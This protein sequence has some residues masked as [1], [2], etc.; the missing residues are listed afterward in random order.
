MTSAS[1]SESTA[2]PSLEPRQLRRWL[3]WPLAVVS[4][5][6]WLV[7]LLLRL[8][9][10]DAWQPLAAVFYALP[11]PVL[12]A[13]GLVAAESFRML[14]WRRRMFAMYASLVLQLACWLPT[15]FHFRAEEAPKNSVRLAFWNVSR[16][17][18]GYEHAARELIASNPDVVCL[19]EATGKGQRPETWQ[20]HFPGFTVHPLG[21]GMVLLVRGEA[22]AIEPGMVRDILKYRSMRLRVGGHRFR[23]VLVDII[24]DPL[25]SRAPAFE[26]LSVLLPTPAGLPTV[27][28]GDFNTPPESVHFR[29]LPATW[30]NA[31]DASGSG[32]R[33]TWPIFTPVLALDQLWG[34]PQIHWHRCEYGWSTRSDHRALTA[35]FSVELPQ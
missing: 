32:Y 33:A 7:G 2:A 17:G 22:Y 30:T 3:W 9:L 6:T 29:H 21:S 5:A 13:G 10:R 15:A 12:L 25:E 8:T 35:D 27:L 28:V 19:V 31:F 34:S 18:R 23:L 1:T 16:G 20:P 4:F 11:T 14:R 26:K 24:S